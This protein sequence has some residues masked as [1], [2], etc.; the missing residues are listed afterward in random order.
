MKKVFST[1]F[2]VL[3]LTAAF[4]QA[5]TSLQPAGLCD[6]GCVNNADALEQTR[7]RDPKLTQ[8]KKDLNDCL[9]KNNCDWRVGK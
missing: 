8:W 9:S 5:N 2:A 4:S 7:P 3:F 6:M 1:F